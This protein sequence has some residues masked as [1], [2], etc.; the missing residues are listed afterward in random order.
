[1][2]VIANTRGSL[3]AACFEDILIEKAVETMESWE[4]NLGENQKS[5][6]FCCVFGPFGGV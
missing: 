4:A 6:N 2:L 3:A 5:C 1:M